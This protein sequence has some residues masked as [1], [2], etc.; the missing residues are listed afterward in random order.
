MPVVWLP[1]VKDLPQLR[2]TT[3]PRSFSILDIMALQMMLKLTSYVGYY[4]F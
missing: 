4:K 2:L 1:L 3:D